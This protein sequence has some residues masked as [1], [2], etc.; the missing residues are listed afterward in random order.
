MLALE[1]ACGSQ[2]KDQIVAE[3]YELGATG[4]LEKESGLVAYFPAHVDPRVIEERLAG[5]R[6]RM[7]FESDQDWSGRWR[8]RW[9][10]FTVGE[11]FFLV[12][13]WSDEPTPAG[14]IRLVLRPGRACGTGLHP[15]THLCLEA[16][17]ALVRPGHVILDVGTGS[18][19]LAVAAARLGAGCVIACDLAEEAIEE[20][21]RRFD[22]EAPGTLLYQGSLRSLRSGVADVV[23][24]NISAPAA[25]Q[26]APEVRRV[27]KT[28]AA[29]VISGFRVGQRERVRAALGAA[30]F[31][32]P[33]SRERDGWQALLCYTG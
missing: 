28:G 33:E 31:A 20:A 14:R 17:E 15:C 30:G 6:L 22:Q 12:P 10:G 11:R 32:E 25:A 13:E 24:V 29:A 5:L 19:L 27:S 2:P 1:I 21:R 3:L 26:L 7:V 8:E 9:S 4:I 23:I 18:G 16:M